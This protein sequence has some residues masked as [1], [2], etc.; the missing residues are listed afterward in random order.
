MTNNILEKPKSTAEFALLANG[1]KTSEVLYE[2]VFND[3]DSLEIVN[4]K[5]FTSL[6]LSAKF[7]CLMAER[8]VV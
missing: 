7:Q 6:A 2:R 4:N 1:N 3:E 8:A 5:T